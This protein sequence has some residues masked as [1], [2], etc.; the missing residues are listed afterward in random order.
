MCRSVIIRND[1]YV[2]LNTSLALEH[3]NNARLRG[4]ENP[5][6]MPEVSGL[7]STASHTLA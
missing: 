1:L 2:R 7:T 6:T 4:C 5:F 3:V